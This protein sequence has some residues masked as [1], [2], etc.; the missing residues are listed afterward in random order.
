MDTILT[1]Q[2]RENLVLDLY[3]NQNKNTREIS[4][5]AKMSF[6]EIG[7]ILDKARKE[8]EASKE[9]TEKQSLSTQAYKLFSEGKTPTQV[10]IALNKQQPE[11]TELQNEYW[12]LN[13]LY[14]LN[15]I[16]QE[17][18]GNLYSFLE[19]YRQM[20]AA[21]MYI[22][23]VINL[24]RVANNDIP[25]VEHRCQELRKDA[26]SL[27]AG[28]RNA[29]RTL[30]QLTEVISETQDTSD[31]Y[32]LVCKQQK[33]EMD[34]LYLQKTQLE[35]L[36]EDFKI[37][38]EGYRKVIENVK[39]EVES[40]IA[41]PKQFLK[42]ALSSLIESL[43]M[44]PDKFQL[45]Y[46]QMSAEKTTTMPTAPSPMSTPAY[47]SQN[48]SE[49]YISE[50][51]PFQDYNNP[52]EAFENFVLNEAEKL[53]AKL[54][55]DSIDKTISNIPNDSTLNVIGWLNKVTALSLVSLAI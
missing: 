7:T 49:F 18:R 27:N 50:Q 26:A 46:Y 47:S 21:G 41:N 22:D 54:L 28:N 45:L 2:Q 12:K 8:K 43:R 30:R 34:R 38:N 11:V 1:R 33:S 51:Y 14:I 24:L 31:H 5:I 39:Q 23:S 48:C 9:Q 32:S 52:T 35:E 16:C 44:D 42:W 36:V 10:A 40:T 37:N 13:Q 15:Q 6:R 25:S 20:K 4:Q 53:Y 55:E 17:T 3:F 29:A 19:L